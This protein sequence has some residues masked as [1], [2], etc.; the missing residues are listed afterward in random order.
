MGDKVLST[1]PG[2]WGRGVESG[3][4]YSCG[5]DEQ[6]AGAED[7]RHLP[8]STFSKASTWMPSRHLSR[9]QTVSTWHDRTALFGHLTV[10][11]VRPL[12]S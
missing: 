11:E 5:E 6:S 2:Q 3:D 7:W 10:F 4:A 12:Y 9:S 1:N 8:K